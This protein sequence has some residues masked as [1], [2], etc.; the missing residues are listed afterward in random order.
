M[1]TPAQSRAGSGRPTPPGGMGDRVEIIPVKSMF[2]DRRA[3][4][5]YECNDRGCLLFLGANQIVPCRILDQSASGAKVA[6][7]EDCK[8][9]PEIWLIDL[10]TH[11]VRRGQSAWFMP[12]RMGLRFNLILQLSKTEPKPSKVPQA[13]YDTWLKL[14][15]GPE[16]P[17]DDDVLFL[18]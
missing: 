1:R 11:S 8:I 6:F 17:P 13:V 4:P 16:T 2:D 18:D 5:R 7:Q 10:D 9:T 3:E 14:T 15:G 12:Y